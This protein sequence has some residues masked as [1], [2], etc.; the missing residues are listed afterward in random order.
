MSARNGKAYVTTDCSGKLRLKRPI[1]GYEGD[2]ASQ[3]K[4]DVMSMLRLHDLK[5]AEAFDGPT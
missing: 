3:D 1:V 4:K 2:S 5:V